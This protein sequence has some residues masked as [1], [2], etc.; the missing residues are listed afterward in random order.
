MC[1][2]FSAGE[3]WAVAAEG[4]HGERDQRVWVLEPERDAGEEPDL[5]VG[6]FDEPVGQSAVE[7]DVDGVAVT[8]DAL[9]ELDERGDPAAAGPLDP[10]VERVFAGFSAELEHDSQRF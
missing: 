1:G 8:N 5:G 2:S 9:R 4:E 3:F 7:R 6:R 10:T